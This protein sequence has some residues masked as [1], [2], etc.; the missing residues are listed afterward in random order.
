MIISQ[1]AGLRFFERLLF[2][3]DFD[4]V[5]GVKDRRALWRKLVDLLAEH[6]KHCQNKHEDADFGQF[7]NGIDTPMHYLHQWDEVRKP[8]R[9]C[10]L[11]GDSD[12]C[13]QTSDVCSPVIPVAGKCVTR[14]RN[15]W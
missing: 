1:D 5:A 12:E 4:R 2:E 3:S 9:S 15:S 14:Q 13:G 10:F 7:A 11:H 8:E 6:H